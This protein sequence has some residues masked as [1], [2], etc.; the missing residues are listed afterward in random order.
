MTN[1]RPRATS[2]T[3]M[4]LR[5]QSITAGRFAS[6]EIPDESCRRREISVTWP[7]GHGGI[8]HDDRQTSVCEREG[9]LLGQQLRP[10]IGA[11]RVLQRDLDILVDRAGRVRLGQDALRAGMQHALDPRRE[12]GVQHVDRT[13]IVR[14]PGIRLG[15]G[16]RGWD[17]PPGGRP[18]VLPPSPE[19][20]RD[21]SRMSKGT[22]IDAPW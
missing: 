10:A 21:R 22:K 9:V 19:P 12:G 8:R 13:L 6:T 11:D 1:R 17:S 18:S 4:R 2:R 15:H 20:T 3:S 16:P 14:P 7:D 5:V